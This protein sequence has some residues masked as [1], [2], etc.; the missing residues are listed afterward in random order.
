MVQRRECARQ[1][2]TLKVVKADGSEKGVLRQGSNAWRC[3]RLMVQRRECARQDPTV[4]AVE[5]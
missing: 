5:G 2:P 4:Q 3:C 1:G